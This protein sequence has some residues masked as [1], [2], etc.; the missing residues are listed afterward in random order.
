M[1]QDWV[2]VVVSLGVPQRVEAGDSSVLSQRLK[3]AVDVVRQLDARLGEAPDDPATGSPTLVVRRAA[4]IPHVF[5]LGVARGEHVS[6][7][8][9][10]KI[11]NQHGIVDCHQFVLHSGTYPYFATNFP[12]TWKSTIPKTATPSPRVPSA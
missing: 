4:V 9:C 6:Q 1:L 10:M 8:G 2:P 5:V 7:L 11:R 3:L 12:T